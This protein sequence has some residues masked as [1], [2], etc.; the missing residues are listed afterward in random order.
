MQLVIINM[1]VTVPNMD[2]TVCKVAIAAEVDDI[3]FDQSVHANRQ[4]KGAR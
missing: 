2:R 1:S 4:N 3:L